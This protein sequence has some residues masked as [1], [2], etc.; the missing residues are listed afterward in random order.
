MPNYRR[1]FVPGGTFFFT[2]VTHQRQ[3]F[4]AT[5][6]ARKCLRQ[7]I[8]HVRR[9][10]PFVIDGI[11]L[12][13]DHLHCIFTLPAEDSDYSFRWSRMK[14]KFSQLYSEQGG[15][16]ST[17]TSSREKRGERGFWQRRFYEHTI[18]DWADFKRCLDYLHVN[19]LKH[20]HVERV[21]DWPWSSFHRYV[22]LGEYTNDWGSAAE[23]YGDDWLAME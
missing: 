15:T 12:L 5:E 22:R 17:I 9:R 14:A 7:S 1:N 6:L 8:Q 23:F 16:E 10:H 21:S 13:P 11:V 20:H 3:P 2:L 19:P 4:L 18:R